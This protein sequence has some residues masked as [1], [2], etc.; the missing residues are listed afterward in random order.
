[1]HA[2]LITCPSGRASNVSGRR[3]IA[4]AAVAMLVGTLS[5]APEPAAAADLPGSFKGEAYGTLATGVVGPI[6]AT[7]GRSA[8]LPCPC[9]GTKGQTLTNQINSLSAGS[10][11]PGSHR[12]H[13]EE[14]RFHPE[15]GG[16]G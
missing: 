3:P 12:G 8:Y 1:M 15:D 6:A 2:Q 7:L 4:L 5:F 13:G 14:H 11:R 10:G 16:H 9:Q